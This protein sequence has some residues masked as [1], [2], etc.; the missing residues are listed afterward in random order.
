[1]SVIHYR[2]TSNKNWDTVIF[3]GPAISVLDIKRGIVERNRLGQNQ[4]T[5]DFEIENQQTGEVYE[6]DSTLV[7]KNTS[8]SVRRV[9]SNRSWDMI[10]SGNKGSKRS[11]PA[12][13]Y[14][15]QLP[16]GASEEEKFKA[17][18]QNS[19]MSGSSGYGYQRYDP[20]AKPPPGYICYRCGK[21]GHYKRY[22]TAVSNKTSSDSAGNG[23]EE[24]LKKRAPN[25]NEFDRLLVRGEYQVRSHE[26][27]YGR[28]A[29][30]K[31]EYICPLCKKYIRDAVT[32]CCTAS[33][34]NECIRQAVITDT[35]ECPNCKSDD[36][37]M[38][39]IKPNKKL[40]RA[41]KNF[42]NPP[43]PKEVQ[44]A[45]KEES[46]AP[47]ESSGGV[48][49]VE[50]DTA[51]GPRDQTNA[52]VKEEVEEENAIDEKDA[53]K[54][55]EN[56]SELA[57]EHEDE[58]K[59]AKEDGADQDQNQ[60]DEEQDEEP[61][62]L[63]REDSFQRIIAGKSPLTSDDDD[64][65]MV[66]QPVQQQRADDDDE[67]QKEG[68]A[69]P[70]PS[71]RPSS[72]D[73]RDSRSNSE[74]D[75]EGRQQPGQERGEGGYD[76]KEW[77][78]NNRGS[79]GV[80]PRNGPPHGL[81]NGR[82]PPFRGQGPP[83]GYRGGPPRGPPPGWGP[84]GGGGGWRDGPPPAWNGPPGPWR[85]GPRPWGRG[86]GPMGRPG[87]GWGPRGRGFPPRMMMGPG[88]MGP[89]STG[90]YGP[91]SGRDG[92]AP[93]HRRSP[94]RR[95]P[96][97][98]S[99]ARRSPSRRDD[100]NQRSRNHRDRDDRDSRERPRERER[101]R[102]S[103]GRRGSRDSRPRRSYSDREQ[104]HSSELRSKDRHDSRNHTKGRHTDDI[105]EDERGPTARAEE[106]ETEKWKGGGEA[107]DRGTEERTTNALTLSSTMI[108]C[109]TI[110]FDL[111]C[112]TLA[113]HAY[114]STHFLL[115]QTTNENNYCDIVSKHSCSR[116]VQT[117]YMVCAACGCARLRAK[118]ST[119]QLT[120]TPNIL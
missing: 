43:K 66:Q 58:E 61:P 56:N 49:K 79:N 30:Q 29:T 72:R 105:G 107:P 19:Q 33:F 82:R 117:S 63:E 96:A 21:P 57:Q 16:A 27:A 74:D 17:I 92:N 15:K 54:T 115:R 12:P 93:F 24:V 102:E 38:D 64:D 3:D 40:R 5:F 35:F 47:L 81:H 11:Q 4:D 55:E 91:L 120:T 113:N 116:C 85:G 1:M 46:P 48:K 86:P 119:R 22:C 94:A 89:A 88:R 104:G 28:R 41:I 10:L 110:T 36:V 77:E 69:S 78:D 9:P 100:S 39:D 26:Y 112:P 51:S 108:I 37:D 42:L 97:R 83:A 8:I 109:D 2:F 90:R 32:A 45:K 103:Q 73:G 23:E 50:E 67:G 44:E 65:F 95:S 118:L 14:N 71:S 13:R 70:K 52:R 98:R 68:E 59:E 31:A 80:Y 6:R 53:K 106:E 18:L 111:I 20:S 62:A 114:A 101:D 7:P 99:P 84:G 76:D 87:P 25:E 60:D 34:C 75:R